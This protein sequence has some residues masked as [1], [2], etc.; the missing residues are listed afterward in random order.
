[1]S[2]KMFQNL[3]LALLI[4]NGSAQLLKGVKTSRLS[5]YEV[6]IQQILRY[7]FHGLILFNRFEINNIKML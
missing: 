5:K 2:S 4:I 3:V 1:M 6:G 7:P